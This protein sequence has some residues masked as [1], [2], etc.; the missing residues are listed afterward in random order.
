MLSPRRKAALIAGAV[1]LVLGG[2][3]IHASPMSAQVLEERLQGAAD[4]AL[5]AMR[6][7]E[8]ARVEINGQTAT[9]SGL[10]PSRQA[11]DSALQ[12]VATASWA[13]GVVAGG[14]TEVYDQIRLPG[15][16]ESFALRL[17]L[18][19][20]RM[21]LE[22]LIPDAETGERLADLAREESSGRVD[23]QFRLAPGGAPAGWERMVSDMIQALGQ[24]DAGAGLVTRDRAAL[25]GLA[26]SPAAARDVRSLFA[27][28]PVGFQAAALVRADGGSYQTELSDAG[29]CELLIKGALGRRPIA[30]A[31]GRNTLTNESR[32]ALR[33]AGE[34]YAACVG[35]G[36]LIIAVRADESG[37]EGAGLAL[38]RGEAAADAMAEAGVERAHFLAEAAPL[39]AQDAM[40]FRLTPRA[41]PDPMTAELEEEQG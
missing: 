17:D 15:E 19:G 31:P 38:M 5:Y 36:D 3:A 16:A 11:R 9:L 32:A 20:G 33:R 25:T 28:A 26:P 27:D 4:D 18:T 37:D 13:G 35:A 40:Q 39:G 6:A 24:L 10:A 8:W 34:V 29:L 23:V 22:G 7:D 21:R 41:A 14:V 30:F 2:V 1:F 12:A